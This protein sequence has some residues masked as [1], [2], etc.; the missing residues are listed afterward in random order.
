[1]RN[2]PGPTPPGTPDS[3]ERDPIECD[4][5]G[6]VAQWRGTVYRCKAGH[7]TRRR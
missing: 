7:E 6:Q 1:M 2:S 4:E 3:D 5:C